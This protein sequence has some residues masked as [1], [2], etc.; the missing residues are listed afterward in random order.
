M[1]DWMQKDTRIEQVYDSAQKCL[2]NGIAVI[3]N[4]IV[5][6]PHESP[7][8]IDESLRVA[9]VLRKMSP[10]FELGIFY[11][12]PYPG[13]AIADQLLKEGYSFPNGLEEWAGFDYVGSAN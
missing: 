5:G 9:Q 8:S 6:F 1:M 7:A 4:I 12:K 2:R 10:N 13:N 11:F 3:F